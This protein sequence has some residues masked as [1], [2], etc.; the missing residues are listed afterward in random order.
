MIRKS[1]YP[2]EYTNSWK[3]FEEINLPQ[4]DSF[5]SRLNM[6]GIGDQD[7]KHVQQVWRWFDVIH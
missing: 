6:K 5:Y 7:Y 4:K 3:K 2:Y 1:A